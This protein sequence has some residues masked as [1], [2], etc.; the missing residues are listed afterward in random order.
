MIYLD[1]LDGADVLGR[2]QN[3]WKY[4]AARFVYSLCHSLKRPAIMEMSTF[5]H[6]L[7]F[8]RSR[9][10][11]WDA[12]SKGYKRYID[13][14]FL[15]NKSCRQTFLPAN[16]GWWCVFD[17]APKDRMRTF[18][19]DLEYLLCKAIAGD[20]SLSWLMGFDPETFGKS[21]NARRLGALV[22]QYEDLRLANYFPP[23]VREKL[24]AP[25]SD[26]T[27]EKTAEGRWQ[28]RPVRYDVH[29]VLGLDGTGKRWKVENKFRKQPLKV[30]IEALL[31]LSPYE[32]SGEVLAAFDSPNEFG[33][34]Q[35]SQGVAASLLTVSTPVGSR[36][37]IK[38]AR[39]RRDFVG[40]RGASEAHIRGYVTSEQRSWTA[41]DQGSLPP[42]FLDGSL[43]AGPRSG[44]FSAKSDKTN[45]F[46]AW[47]MA[48]KTF[49][50]P[51]NLL[52]K[53]FGVWIYGDGKGEVL[54]F[55]WRAPE[56]ISS[57]LSEHYALIDFTG[58]RYFEFVEP[59]S[60]RLMD[61]GWPYFYANPDQEFG[62]AERLRH[63]NRFTGTFWVDY[64]NLDSLKLWYNH[65][66]QGEEVKCYLGPVKALPHV[67]AK[68][69]NPSIKIGGDA[70]TFPTTLESGTYLEF[71][72]RNDCK[73][74]DAKGALVSEI[75]PQGNIPQLE[76]GNDVVQF[77]CNV[78]QEGSARANVTIISQDDKFVGQ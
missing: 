37:E 56:H 46:C 13:Q 54:N 70:I 73:V 34:A 19:D 16:L 48:A 58:W 60:D 3:G 71:R 14:H 12:P 15:E 43:K 77:T 75:I 7:W 61:Y 47:A 33:P 64:A 68:L 10:G 2:W 24:G 28:F 40:Q 31:S 45:T 17:W 21:S 50:K 30:R 53:G 52:E 20:H 8:A 9:V 6:H 76:A 38:V 29:K 42:S 11:A 25:D 1:A 4:Y 36:Q 69:V 35:A 65:L 51:V 55:Q 74:Y 72:S 67:K 41:K 27:L 78:P 18:P 63:F 26:F 5:D 22:R 32:G 49:S 57:G 62:G 23:S 59:E 66:P 39:C 44:C